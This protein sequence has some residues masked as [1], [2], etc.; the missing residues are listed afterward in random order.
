LRPAPK[1]PIPGFFHR[2]VFRPEELERNDSHS[3]PK[4]A[5]ETADR[6]IG[7][8]WSPCQLRFQKTPKSSAAAAQLRRIYLF[9]VTYLFLNCPLAHLVRRTFGLWAKSAQGKSVG[10]EAYRCKHGKG[11]GPAKKKLRQQGAERMSA[12]VHVAAYRS[13]PS[14]GPTF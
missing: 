12:I 2:E 13:V 14:F 5:L 6:L 10:T 3:P 7:R 11:K 8:A 4:A 1:R 9:L